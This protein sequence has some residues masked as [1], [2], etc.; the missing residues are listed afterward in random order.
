MLQGTPWALFVLEPYNGE[1]KA[2][3]ATS[4]PPIAAPFP[5]ASYARTK[6]V[7]GAS[8]AAMVSTIE[9]HY[10]HKVRVVQRMT[11]DMKD[12]FETRAAWL[13]LK[14]SHQQQRSAA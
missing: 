8:L 11:D 12:V 10:G 4:S 6:P 7:T 3:V 13:A 1:G 14:E 2:Y 5:V 9:R